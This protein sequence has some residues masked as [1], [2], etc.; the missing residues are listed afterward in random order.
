MVDGI[1]R[2]VEYLTLADGSQPFAEWLEGLDKASRARVNAG[3]DKARRG[4]RKLIRALGD[5]VYEI[6]VDFG[7]GY[8]VYFGEDGGR[9]IL[10][11]SGGDKKSQS[12]DIEKAKSLWRSYEKNKKLR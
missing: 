5:G 3:I 11:I 9:L 2:K 6:K 4:V 1:E 12:Q 8:R 7:P 10:L